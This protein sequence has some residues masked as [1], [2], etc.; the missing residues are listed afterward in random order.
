[1]EDGPIIV[2]DAD[3]E[4][5]R[6]LLLRTNVVYVPREIDPRRRKVIARL[7]FT[8]YLE[9][10][11]AVFIFCVLIFTYALSGYTSEKTWF[12]ITDVYLLISIFSKLVSIR[13]W[14]AGGSEDLFHFWFKMLLDLAFVGWTIYGDILASRA[15]DSYYYRPETTTILFAIIVLFYADYLMIYTFIVFYHVLRGYCRATPPR[16]VVQPV[17]RTA[18]QNAL[19]LTKKQCRICME[20]FRDNDYVV[21]LPCNQSHYFHDNC[22]VVWVDNNGDC[23]I[24]KTP[25]TQE[26]LNIA[27][28]ERQFANIYFGAYYA[29]MEG[30]EANLMNTIFNVQLD[31]SVIQQEEVKEEHKEEVKEEYKE[32]NKDDEEQYSSLI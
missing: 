26:A 9:I 18:P 11:L 22:V 32:E 2:R 23:S 31:R 15:F 24:C 7:E 16:P 17:V 30:S 3:Q 21:V 8:L 12:I 1:M 10:I 28:E 4:A 19:I 27:I 5:N 6:S 14:K 29:G 25:I 20:E 13:K